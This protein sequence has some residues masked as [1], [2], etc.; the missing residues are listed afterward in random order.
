[1]EETGILKGLGDRR[2]ISI[3][4]EGEPG[5][6]VE[7]RT[8]KKNCFPK[9][10][11]KCDKPTHFM[12]QAQ[13]TEPTMYEKIIRPILF[14]MDAE[15]AHEWTI[16]NLSLA[17]GVPWICKV[18]HKWNCG[19]GK[20]A[21]RLFGLDFPNRLGLAAGMDKDGRCPGAFAAMGFGH[22]EAGTVTPVGQLGND[23]PR[24][25]R[26]PQEE[27]V[28]NRMGF[29]NHGAESMASRIS[30][31]YPK[32]P[33]RTAVLGINIGKGKST[34][35]EEAARD[36]V[37][38]FR[39]LAAQADYFTVNISSPNTPGLRQLQQES[40]LRELLGS[41]QQANQ[42]RSTETGEAKIPILVKIAPD[43][44]DREIELVVG[45]LE[46]LG[47]DGV[48]ATNTT[49]ARPG[50]FGNVN[51]TGGLSGLPLQSR[52]DDV[53]RLIHKVSGGGMPII[54]V[55][56]IMDLDSAQRKIDLGASLVQI[57]T[58]LIYKGPGIV[59]KIAQAI[60]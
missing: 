15:E 45:L 51:E 55:G 2:I 52:S 32:G 13:R 4:L 6:R 57:Y 24:L 16:R 20:G 18:L 46:V 42:E 11:E 38:G 19:N 25:F 56:G 60:G 7:F 37:A 47:Y 30:K 9:F 31:T 40:Y 8:P 21:V 17:S 33:G 50:Y 35:I 26:Y 28:I 12:N 41:L 3:Y 54:G 44:E 58:G 1:V 10:Q 48:I 29:N 53:I 14:R 34:P 23:K 49:V 22:V 36:Y 43:L 59:R 27:A 5:I 39:E